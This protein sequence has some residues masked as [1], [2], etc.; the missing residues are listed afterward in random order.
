MYRHR[1][2]VIVAGEGGVGKTTLL[3]KY[4]SGIFFSETSMTLGVQFHVKYVSVGDFFCALQLWDLGGQ[5]QFRFL[6][7]SYVRGAEGALLVFDLTRVSTLNALDEWTKICRTYN[8]DL[9]ILLCGAK[10]DLTERRSVSPDVARD[11]MTELEFLDYFE[12]SAKTGEN[13]A[14]LF[15]VLAKHLTHG[16]LENNPNQADLRFGNV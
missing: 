12:V 10:V 6:L 7:P 9:P 4:V 13:V 16:F 15:E 5:E 11:Y 2:K 1:I 14:P 8:P 3:Y